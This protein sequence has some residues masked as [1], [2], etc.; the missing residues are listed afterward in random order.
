MNRIRQIRNEK[1]LNQTEVSERANMT[2]QAYRRLESDSS[3]PNLL[4]L[5]K[6]AQA[7]NVSVKE[8]IEDPISKTECWVMLNTK[9]GVGKT[10]LTILIATALSDLGY[11]VTVVDNDPQASV[12]GVF[13][14][15]ILSESEE[16]AA[17]IHKQL[18]RH[19]IN[20]LMNDDSSLTEVLLSD[21]S[22]PFQLIGAT[23][24]FH[25]ALVNFQE[26]PG[27]DNLQKI[28][29]SGLDCDFIIID[30]PGTSNLQ[31][32]WSLAMA[33]RII[34]PIELD[35]IA[36]DP[37]PETIK[38]IETAKKYLNPFV[39]SISILPNKMEHKNICRFTLES[40]KENYGKYLSY[41]SDKDLFNIDD[42]E[43]TEEKYVIG[44]SNSAT[45]SNFL[46][47]LQSLPK[48]GKR[49]KVYQQVINFVQPLLDQKGL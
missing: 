13:I 2:R 49:S 17:H 48:K 26:T 35:L 25:E 15:P 18:I 7:L 28:K 12:T 46:A 21:E 8:L 4:T 36:I 27:R 24:Q 11:R 22:I 31:I 29:L 41:S 30:T 5:Q 19:N 1:N 39:K 38:K 10:T 37:L 9:G 6:V 33:D 45:I 32:N 14:K 34:V 43:Q 44:V 42:R 47:G 20:T 16:R 40:I 23:D 3:N